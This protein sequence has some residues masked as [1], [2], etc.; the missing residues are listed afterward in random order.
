MTS[1]YFSETTIE[2][3][4]AT[5]AGAEAHH[6]AR[7][8]RAQVGDLVNLF[9]GSGAEFLAR[10]ERITKSGVEFCIEERRE[11]DRELPFGLTLAVA[12]PKG[13]RQRWLVEKAV[14]LG[15]SRL[16]P[17][18]TTRGVADGRAAIER[19]LRAVIEAS[20]QCGRN[21]LM[22]VASRQDWSDIVVAPCEGNC[23][24]LIAHPADAAQ[25][26]G[27]DTSSDQRS[28]EIIV[29]VGP[30]GGWTEQE[31]ALARDNGW[32]FVDLGPRILRV[33]TAA[34]AL[35]SAIV[36]RRW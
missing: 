34:I 12:L 7:V 19:L 33:E 21:R 32:R 35:A 36:M 27:L 17:V 22:E 28:G 6:L 15:V 11:V 16:I 13:D 4:A 14:E 24:R 20:K 9:D 29:A 1:R 31:V 30:E 26:I 2:N 8:M 3:D 25:P 23:T 10:I 18:V 5:L